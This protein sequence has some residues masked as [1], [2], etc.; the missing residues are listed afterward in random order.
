MA[1]A[2]LSGTLMMVTPA[3][4]AVNLSA[5]GSSQWQNGSDASGTVMD[6]NSSSQVGQLSANNYYN[7]NVNNGFK[8]SQNTAVSNENGGTLV[9]QQTA[10]GGSS[11]SWTKAQNYTSQGASVSQGQSQIMTSAGEDTGSGGT[12][13][14]VS[15]VISGT[16]NNHNLSGGIAANK[17]T[18]NATVDGGAMQSTM[19]Q[20]STVQA[21]DTLASGYYQ[22]DT[23]VGSTVTNSNQYTGG[24]LVSSTSNTNLGGKSFTS[25]S[26]F[27]NPTA[28]FT[29]DQNQNIGLDGFGG[30]QHQSAGAVAGQVTGFWAGVAMQQHG[31]GTSSSQVN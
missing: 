6:Q 27:S 30:T 12:Q 23:V 29:Q 16:L 4:A 24:V 17:Q 31:D 3:F 1:A 10:S 20:T 15:G 14:Q 18:Q 2:V 26:S 8:S 21:G 5:A 9:S 22:N 19:N 11:N 13:G 7:S 25:A 28:G